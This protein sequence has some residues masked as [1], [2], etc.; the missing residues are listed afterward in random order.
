MTA[1]LVTGGA[2]F[3]GF[4]FVRMAVDSD[5]DTLVVLYALAYADN[6]Y[7]IADLI[8]AHRVRFCNGDICDAENF[9]DLFATYR[10]DCVVHFAAESHV[11]QSILGP[12]PFLRDNIEG[13]YVLIEAARKAWQ[14]Q[15]DCR[16]IHVSTDEVFGDL[17]PDDPPFTEGSTVH[18][19]HMLHPRRLPTIW[20]ARGIG[21]MGCRL[22]LPT[23][24]TILGHGNSPGSSFR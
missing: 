7:N 13:A 11:D 6:V 4:N 15:T 24:A 21:P 18:R 10:F 12:R 5:V 17:A 2:G 9:E 3:I 8:E 19:V 1:W 22:L 20:Y 14:G 23:A 16:F